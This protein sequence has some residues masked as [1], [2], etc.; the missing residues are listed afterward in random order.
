MLIQMLLP[1]PLMIRTED[2][3]WLHFCIVI[4]FL[5]Q[6]L[7][8]LSNTFIALFSH[9]QTLKPGRKKVPVTHRLVFVDG[10]LDTPAALRD[11][12]R[13]EHWDGW[14]SKHWRGQREVYTGRRDLLVGIRGMMW[15]RWSLKY[16]YANLTE[17]RML[18]ITGWTSP[19]LSLLINKMKGLK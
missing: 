18:L 17:H 11:P 2:L 9:R 16:N 13:V 4:V 10:V 19:G 15:V 6:K 12:G 14:H 7:N 3:L 5:W 1:S 8:Q